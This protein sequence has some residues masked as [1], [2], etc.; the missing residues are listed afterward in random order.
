MT[1][2]PI[3]LIIGSCGCGIYYQLNEVPFDVNNTI[4]MI[5]IGLA[6]ALVSM[7]GFDKVKQTIEQMLPK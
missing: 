4:Y 6:S 3:L 1:T 5:L 2:V 7:T